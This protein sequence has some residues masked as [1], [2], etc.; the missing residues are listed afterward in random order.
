MRVIQEPSPLASSK[1]HRRDEGL[2]EGLVERGISDVGDSTRPT[3]TQRSRKR[4][5][6]ALPVALSLVA[7]AQGAG[8]LTD[9]NLRNDLVYDPSSGNVQLHVPDFTGTGPI[10]Q[11]SLST[12]ATFDFSDG[13]V[14]TG[15]DCGLILPAVACGNLSEQ[16]ISYDDST[17]TGFDGM[18]DLGGILPPGLSAPG[19]QQ[20]LTAAS[21]RTANI[22]ADTEFDIHVV[23]EPNGWLLSGL[24]MAL[25]L[26]MRRRRSQ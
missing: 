8:N 1:A 23:P 26:A 12:D 24:G 14:T 9:D 19:V 20:F 6:L 22:S 25:S 10:V 17:T 16:G 7:G 21:Y 13:L 15:L 18:L 5:L 4:F 2:P 3:R 11:F